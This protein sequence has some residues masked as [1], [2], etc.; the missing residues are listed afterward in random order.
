[1]DNIER[2]TFSSDEPICNR[3][4]DLLD[5][6]DF[7]DRLANVLC[8]AAPTTAPL[9]IG[10]YG[11]WGS[12]KTSVVNLVAKQLE[13]RHDVIAALRFEPWNYL[14]SSQLVEQF[15]HQLAQSLKLAKARS[16]A[17]LG[18]AEAFAN[19]SQTLLASGA[20]SPIL[21]DEGIA[22]GIAVAT[23]GG[24]F[25]KRL[26]QK[27]SKTNEDIAQRKKELIGK[28]S[29]LDGRIVVFVDDIDRLPNENIR[30]MFQLIASLA[31]LPNISYL[32]SFDEE[33]VVASLSEVQTGNGREYL[34]KIVQVPVK[35]PNPPHSDLL[36]ILVESIDEAAQRFGYEEADI[37]ADRWNSIWAKVFAPHYRTLRQVKRYSNALRARLLSSSPYASFLD[38]VTLVHLELFAGDLATWISNNKSVVCGSHSSS[39]LIGGTSQTQMCEQL[40]AHLDTELSTTDADWALDILCLMFPRIAGDTGKIFSAFDRSLDLNG[41]W[42]DA[43]FDMYFETNAGEGID[44]H[45]I[46]N[47]CYHLGM[48]QIA[49]TFDNHSES[50]SAIQFIYAIQSHSKAI[51]EER[52]A[53]ICE[54][55]LAKLGSCSETARRV[56]GQT[57][58]DEEIIRFCES[59]FERLGLQESGEIIA[60]AISDGA[61]RVAFP[62][63]LF[64]MWQIGS[65]KTDGNNGARPLIEEA[66]LHEVSERV[67]DMAEECAREGMLLRMQGGNYA[68]TLLEE[69]RRPKYLQ[70]VR[71]LVSSNGSEAVLFVA[72][73]CGRFET[74]DS[75]PSSFKFTASRLEEIMPLDDFANLIDEARKDPSFYEMDEQTRLAAAS[76]VLFSRKPERHEVEAEAAYRLLH[77]WE[78]D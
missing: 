77:S 18:A 17:A 60:H 63:S 76:F 73:T 22:I 35:L 47:V 4:D 23:M 71:N 58:A 45:E 61:T 66:R 13:E 28:L 34:Q 26:L 16:N 54:T 65:Y 5:R 21:P 1:M 75:K 6:A 41:I 30:M 67:C 33:I 20:L 27:R 2:L 51:P 74:L 12:G 53:G 19:Y 69:R 15:F 25:A 8:S 29:K 48:E 56:I 57:T 14:T 49:E 70:L 52:L 40:K 44:V 3:S 72:R 62:L 37:D 42:R 68:L 43:S 39:L 64:L 24:T 36:Q 7:A 78:D 31:K 10:L 9:V 46:R 50:G 38:L 55:L 32:L 11:P 59:C